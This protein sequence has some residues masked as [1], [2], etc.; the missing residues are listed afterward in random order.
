MDNCT[1]L[2]MSYK[3]DLWLKISHLLNLIGNVLTILRRNGNSQKQ[4]ERNNRINMDINQEK[5]LSLKKIIKI[6][7]PISDIGNN[8]KKTYVIIKWRWRLFLLSKMKDREDIQTSRIWGSRKKWG[9]KWTEK[10]VMSVSMFG[11]NLLLN[12]M[13]RI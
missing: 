8:L 4:R 7:S 6:R 11:N 3:Q 1:L 12:P 13:M 9:K 5:I 2:K 10:E